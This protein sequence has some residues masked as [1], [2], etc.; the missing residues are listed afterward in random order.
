MEAYL[1]FSRACLEYL[2]STARQPH[3]LHYHDWH[4]SAVPVLYWDMYHKMGLTS[5]KPVL[6]IHNMDNTGECKVRGSKKLVHAQSRPC[7]AGS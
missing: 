4:L 3:I 6:T 2:H 1:Y 5:A 7:E